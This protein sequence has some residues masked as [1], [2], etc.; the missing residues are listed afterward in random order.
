MLRIAI[1]IGASMLGIICTLSLVTGLYA[2]WF[3]KPYLSYPDLP[4]PAAIQFARAGQ[5]VP[6]KVMRC[7]SDNVS[8]NYLTTHAIKDVDTNTHTILPE[9]LVSIAPGCTTSESKINFVPLGTTPG[10]KMF[11]GMVEI[12]GWF[13]TYNVDWHSDIFE[14][15]Q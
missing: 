11:V 2:A 6:L 9:V 14:V 7:N 15:T 10:R 8:H 13:R 3:E 12:H 5:V 4:F 1:N